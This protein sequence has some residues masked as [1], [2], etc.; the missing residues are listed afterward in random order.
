[1]SVNVVLAG[2]KTVL[3]PWLR[4]AGFRS[5]WRHCGP[6]ISSLCRKR[7]GASAPAGR[8]LHHHSINY[9]GGEVA[10][11]INL[12]DGTEGWVS[13]ERHHR[14]CRQPDDER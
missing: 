4:D 12:C 1:M 8:A 3:Q 13:P 5:A 9:D 14:R 2:H 11:S 6:A 10:D 7:D